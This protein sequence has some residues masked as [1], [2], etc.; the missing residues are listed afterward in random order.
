MY[1]LGPG[2]TRIWTDSNRNFTLREYAR[3]EYGT[4]DVAWI[5][6]SAK[7]SRPASSKRPKRRLWLRVRYFLN[8]Y[9]GFAAFD[10]KGHRDSE[11]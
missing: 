7:R 9:R 10:L 8:A 5:V 11:I 1:L 4:P 3:L 6:A 2:N